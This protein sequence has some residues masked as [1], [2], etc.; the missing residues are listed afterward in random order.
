MHA[1]PI[2][3]PEARIPEQPSRDLWSAV[4][5]QA[6]GDTQSPKHRDEARAWIRGECCHSLCELLGIDHSRLVGRVG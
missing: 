6:L 5:L 2:D 4:I 1:I 3:L